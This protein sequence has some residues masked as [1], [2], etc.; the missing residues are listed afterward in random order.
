MKYYLAESTQNTYVLIDCLSQEDVD[1]GFLHQAHKVLIQEDRDDAL[2]LLNGKILEGAFHCSFLLLGQEGLF[3]EFCGN[4]AR[5]I[6]AYIFA[7]YLQCNKAYLHSKKG[8]HLLN[9]KGEGIYSVILPLPSFEIDPTFITDEKRF[10]E[11]YP[12]L[13]FVNMIE[14]HLILQKELSDQEL[15]TLGRS[16]NQHKELFPQGINVNA[17]HKTAEG[18]LYVKTYER[19]VQRLTK[20]CGSGSLSAAAYFGGHRIVQVK[21]PGGDL[22]I[23]LFSDELELIGP[24]I[25]NKKYKFI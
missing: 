22:E 4:G 2:I 20:S 6:A 23:Q 7:K 8:K 14:P 17:C 16:L 11:L 10:Y 19:G 1:P 5:A 13:H 9:K 21:T 25:V 12:D 3:G 24:A 15:V 18:S